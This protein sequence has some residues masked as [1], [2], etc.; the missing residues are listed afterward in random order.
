MCAHKTV[1][2]VMKLWL[3][4]LSVNLEG[5]V[6]F[7]VSFVWRSSGNHDACTAI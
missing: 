2:K 4:F 1:R 3:K 5:A 7:S 6:F